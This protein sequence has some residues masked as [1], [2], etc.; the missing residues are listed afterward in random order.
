MTKSKAIFIL[1]ILFSIANLSFA[2]ESK[3][4]NEVRLTYG[5]VSMEQFAIL[6][7]TS[8][9]GTTVGGIYNENVKDI[10]GTFIGPIMLQYQRSFKDNNFTIG[11]VFGYSKANTDVTYE[12]KPNL[13]YS[14]DIS[15]FILMAQAEYKYI[16][17]KNFQIYSGLGFGVDIVAPSGNDTKGN[18]TPSQIGPALQ[19]TP[20]GLKF[21]SDSFGGNLEL[22]F[23]SKG[24]ISGGIYSRF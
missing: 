9:A 11:G 20:L 14:V 22:G 1:F 24:L 23:G 5:A 12:S 15:Y 13:T 17:N 21:G 7:L 10:D 3:S 8:L 18:S 4:L 2:Q 19:V 6:I 16:K